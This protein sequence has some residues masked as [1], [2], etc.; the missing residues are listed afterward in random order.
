MNPLVGDVAGNTE[1]LISA[2]QQARVQGIDLLLCPEL[3]LTGYPPEDLLLR[4][5][6]IARV[7]TA[8][9]RL[10]SEVRGLTLVLGYP[11]AS[12][13]GLFNVAGVIRD[14]ALIAEYAKQHLP[15]YSVFDEKRYFQPGA[16][17]VLF[18]HLGLRFGL[19]IC[20][21]IWWEGPTREAAAA[22]AQV[23]LNLNASP[24]HAG[25]IAERESLV[26]QRARTHGL[27][28]L[29]ANLVGGQDE[30]VF[31]GASFVVAPDGR[32]THRARAFTETTLALEL[33]A[34]GVPNTADAEPLA[35][36]PGE[37][38]TIY[39]A[40]VLGVR[41]YVQK[42][43]FDGAV[44]GLSGGI[45]SALTL[46]V[47]VDAL[48]AE[49]VEAVLMPSRYTASMSI[50]DALE[51][52]RRL[53]VASRIIPIEPAFRT[54]LDLLEPVF[55]GQPADVTEENIQARC[56]GLILMA[57]SNKSGRILLTTGNKSEMAVGYATLYGDMA[58]GFAPLKDVP[59]TLVYRLAGYRNGCAP[60]IPE[61]VIARP[62]SAELRPNQTDQ[63]SL[64]PYDLLDAIL[65][66]YIE[67]DEGVDAIVA[68]GYPP[69]VVRRV[70][71]LVDRNEYKRRQAPPGVR[72]SRRS[73]GRDRRY[74]ITS[75]F[76]RPSA[77]KPAT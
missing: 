56:R 28:I 62:P 65:K 1:R 53:G 7:E 11:R 45:D 17:A 71:R 12:V 61:R 39:E 29:Y 73:F 46:T 69:D 67:D 48:G 43:G 34:D 36:W 59:K 35:D 64:P 66:H 15:N 41:D 9:A 16:T 31:D 21:D 20:E 57:I 77:R 75:G 32:I 25:K 42:N 22:G 47:A 50:E 30:L 72:I 4:P 5:E 27:T 33:D 54:F 70:A 44:L 76:H 60:V 19:S 13:G 24:F 49:R 63:D 10:Q 58:G 68:R 37:E 74:P 3:V 26:T 52:T 6:F 40:L 38:E 51:Q 14:G 23:L 18:E 8:V 2:A 55:A